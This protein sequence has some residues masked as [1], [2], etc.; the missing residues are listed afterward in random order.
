METISAFEVYGKIKQFLLVK[1]FAHIIV[2]HYMVAPTVYYDGHLFHNRH[3]FLGYEILHLSH[4]Q[5]PQIKTKYPYSLKKIFFFF[6][7]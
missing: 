5:I 1:D 7:A 2:Y 4:L 6:S 3:S